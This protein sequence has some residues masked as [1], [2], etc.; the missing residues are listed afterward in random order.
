MPV[1]CNFL[2]KPIDWFDLSK[3]SLK[4]FTE[5]YFCWFLACVYWIYWISIYWSP[6]LSFGVFANRLW[7]VSKTD[8][9]ILFPHRLVARVTFFSYTF[10]YQFIDLLQGN[11]I[12]VLVTFCWLIMVFGIRVGPRGTKDYWFN[13]SQIFSHATL[14]TASKE[15]IDL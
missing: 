15:Y 2:L 11:N 5:A 4:F 9:W 12:K 7:F 13:P 8:V 10:H 3:I 6:N 1:K 14:I